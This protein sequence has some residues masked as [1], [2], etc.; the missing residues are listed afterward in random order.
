M[1]AFAG[2]GIPYPFNA[3]PAIFSRWLGHVGAHLMFPK[4][5]AGERMFGG[6]G[7][8]AKGLIYS[9]V[10]NSTCFLASGNIVAPAMMHHLGAYVSTWMGNKKKVAQ[11]LGI[12]LE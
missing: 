1:L 11:R 6:F 12:S 9:D 2:I 7:F 5:T 3:I 4:E 10:I 8:F